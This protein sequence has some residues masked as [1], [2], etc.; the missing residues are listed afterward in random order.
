[1]KET[2][3]SIFLSRVDGKK[4]DNGQ[5]RPPPQLPTQ[6]PAPQMPSAM[7]AMMGGIK[8]PASGAAAPTTLPAQTTPKSTNEKSN[9]IFCF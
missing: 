7:S 9:A 3:S 5:V 2:E 4:R 6:P 8:P 1:M